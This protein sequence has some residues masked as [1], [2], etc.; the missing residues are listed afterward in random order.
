MVET[1]RAQQVARIRDFCTRFPRAVLFDEPGGLL[2][3][4]ASGRSLALDLP[5][6]AGVEERLNRESGHPYLLLAYGDGRR[7][8]LSEAGIAFSPDVRN[9]G[10]LPDLPEAVCLRDYQSLL[11][12]LKHELYGHADR[13]PDRGTVRLLMS[14]IAI[15]DGARAAGFDVGRQELELEHHL[16]ELERRTPL[17]PT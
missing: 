11:D 7:L 10:A 6:L 5:G 17:P 2:L 16:R 8:A 14:C 4:V 3:D 9:T 15:L 13:P 12:R 1:S